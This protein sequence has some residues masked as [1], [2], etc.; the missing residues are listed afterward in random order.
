MTAWVDVAPL[1]PTL[2]D[3]GAVDCC[4]PMGWEEDGHDFRNDCWDGK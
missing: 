2:T 3:M 1:A 4:G